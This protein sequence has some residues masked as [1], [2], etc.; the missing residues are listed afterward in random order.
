VNIDDLLKRARRA[1]LSRHANFLGA[2]ARPSIEMKP[3]KASAKTGL[4]KLGGVPDLPVGESWPESPS[5]EFPLHFLCQFDFADLPDFEGTPF[6]SSGMLSFFY[7]FDEE[8]EADWEQPGFVVGV[9]H[10]EA[11]ELVSVP[12][13]DQPEP[14]RALPLIFKLSWDLPQD[15]Y[16]A[17]DWPFADD[18]EEAFAEHLCWID[19]IGADHLLGYPRHNTL[20]YDPSPGD[21]WMPLLTLASHNEPGWCWGDGDNLMIFIERTRLEKLDFSHLACHAG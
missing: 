4:S 7:L 5:D 9:Y 3:V 14:G 21:E 1:G 15:E 6:P 10:H 12:S 18:E 11:G 8:G 13:P 20:A 17:H 19:R 2:A 16:Q